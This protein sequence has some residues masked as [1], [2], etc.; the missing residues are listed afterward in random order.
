MAPEPL[1]HPRDDNQGDSAPQEPADAPIVEPGATSQ[2]SEP[3]R[4]VDA[5]TGGEQEAE[6]VEGARM[7]EVC[8]GCGTRF[9]SDTCRACP[10]CLRALDHNSKQEPVEAEA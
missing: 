2:A 3:V 4:A 7:L 6:P 10:V 9:S 8:S 5:L 1:R